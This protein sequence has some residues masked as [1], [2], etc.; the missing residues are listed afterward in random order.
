MTVVVRK[1]VFMV[2]IKS[3][4]GHPVPDTLSHERQTHQFLHISLI[5]TDCFSSL[6]SDYVD[7]DSLS[8]FS[9][10]DAKLMEGKNRFD[11]VFFS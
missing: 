7:W 11:V 2:E 8:P 1:G 5:C 9:L 6:T 10:S 4:H 3:S